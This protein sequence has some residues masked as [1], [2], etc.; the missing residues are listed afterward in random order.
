MKRDATN[1]CL[2]LTSLALRF[3]GRP[4][5]YGA[6]PLQTRNFDCSSYIQYLFHKIGIKLPRTALEQA[7]LGKKVDLKQQLKTGDLLFFKGGRGHYNPIFPQGIGH[8]IMFLEPHWIIHATINVKPP[9]VIKQK[10]NRWLKRKDLVII[11]RLLS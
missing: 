5:K 6:K 11:R 10:A 7:A 2:I 1:K 4:Y 9:R 3:L 8:V